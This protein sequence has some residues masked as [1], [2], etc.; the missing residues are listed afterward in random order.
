MRTP[1]NPF[2]AGQTRR[3]LLLGAS[4]A[5]ISTALIGPGVES[6]DADHINP[7]AICGGS[8]YSGVSRSVNIEGPD[9]G[10]I[11]VLSIHGNVG[12]S[13]TFCAVTR[14]RFHDQPRFT[15]VLIK[16][17]PPGTDFPDTCGTD[18]AADDPTPDALLYAGPVYRGKDG[19]TI[20]A[21]GR[22]GDC[23]SMIWFRNTDPGGTTTARMVG[24]TA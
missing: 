9:G 13:D 10:R 19:G 18:W 11:G 21:R 17:C 16:R 20:V 2:V 5:I 6:A 24:C 22:I 15:N 1:Q 8:E 3:L 14:R 12:A 7:V 23:V 4:T